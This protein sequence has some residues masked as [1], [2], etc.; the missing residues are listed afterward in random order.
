MIAAALA[1][2]ATLDVKHAICRFALPA[3]NLGFGI[4]GADLKRQD[5]TANGYL[6]ITSLPTS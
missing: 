3:K 1:M 2:K 5:W 4:A 6:V